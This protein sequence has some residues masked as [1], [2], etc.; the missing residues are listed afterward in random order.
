M[1]P[2]AHHCPICHKPTGPGAREFPFCSERC[3]TQ[4]LANW[5]TGEYAIPVVTTEA[6]EHWDI[7]TDTDSSE[8][9]KDE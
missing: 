7:P 3:R 4:D 2:S 8:R 1:A 6:D 5:A 9:A